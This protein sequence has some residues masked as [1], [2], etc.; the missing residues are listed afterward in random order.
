MDISGATPDPPGPFVM[1]AVA[2]DPTVVTIPDGFQASSAG[3]DRPLDDVLFSD[4]ERH[5]GALLDGVVDVLPGKH[6]D[7][8]GG[9]REAAR[10][11][12]AGAPDA[13]CMSAGTLPAAV[14]A[15]SFHSRDG[16]TT[17]VGYAF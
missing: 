2:H 11:L 4:H 17:A 3:H 6:G 15:E 8:V 14:D 9:E 12:A 1:P 10:A 13:A 7:H 16:R 5:V